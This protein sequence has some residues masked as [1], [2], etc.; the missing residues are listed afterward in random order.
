[1]QLSMGGGRTVAP[2]YPPLTGSVWM[3]Q[4]FFTYSSART[5]LSSV[6]NMSL[7]RKPAGCTQ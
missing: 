3:E 5:V 7:A 2:M 6:P 1:V 4:L